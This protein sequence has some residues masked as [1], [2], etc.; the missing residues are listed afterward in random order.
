MSE[1]VTI[2]TDADLPESGAP[3]AIDPMAEPVAESKWVSTCPEPIPENSLELASP[4]AEPA[5]PVSE[6]ASP[7]SEIK[8]TTDP[9]HQLHNFLALHQSGMISSSVL[10]ACLNVPRAVR[11]VCSAVELYSSGLLDDDSLIKYLNNIPHTSEREP[12]ATFYINPVSAAGG[13]TAS[14]PGVAIP[15]PNDVTILPAVP[16]TMPVVVDLGVRVRCEAGGEYQPYWLLPYETFAKAPLEATFIDF[17][18]NQTPL[19]SARFA[20][21][22]GREYQG[23]L[24]VALLNRSSLPYTIKAGASLFHVVRRDLGGVRAEI[25]DASHP[26]FSEKSD[27]GAGYLLQ[28]HKANAL[29]S[30]RTLV[31]AEDASLKDIVCDA[32]KEAAIAAIEAAALSAIESAVKDAA[33]AA[34]KAA[35]S[36]GLLN[37]AT[38]ETDIAEAIKEAVVASL[39]AA[40]KTAIRVAIEDAA[41]AALNAAKVKI[42]NDI[43]QEVSEVKVAAENALNASRAAIS[44]AK[45]AVSAAVNAVGQTAKDD[46]SAVMAALHSV[47]AHLE[48]VGLRIEAAVLQK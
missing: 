5:S 35:F 33:I 17:R 38:A 26:A 43:Q 12:L 2:H 40:V 42:R 32:A 1:P 29:L 10:M 4:A 24:R 15:F 45:L 34:V 11:D 14:G 48:S 19:E 13:Y 21:I 7:A 3:V 46:A 20:A 16:G 25:V 27:S 22:V 18:A 8:Q 30:P 36:G 44:S 39:E 41:I 47:G 9:D 28:E 31:T 23:T 37:L 6:P